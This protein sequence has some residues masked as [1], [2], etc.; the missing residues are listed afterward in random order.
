MRLKIDTSGSQFIVT[1]APEPRM[2][3]DSGSPKLDPTTGLQLYAV[4]VLALDDAGGE[5]ITVTVVG[6]PK[7]VVTQP[8]TLTGLVAIPWAQGDRS[9]VAFRAD[10]LTTTTTTPPV[11]ASASDGVAGGRA[12]K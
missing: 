1:K 9:G 4:Q 3:F 10:T 6:D 8:V 11:P 5:V 2:H 7:V 12:P